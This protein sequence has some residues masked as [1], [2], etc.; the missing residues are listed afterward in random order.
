MNGY[1]ATIFPPLRRL[2]L[3]LSRDTA[4]LLFVAANLLMLSMETALAHSI[5]GTIRPN[6]WIPILFSP[7]AG[8]WI[9]AALWI[10]RRHP[11]LG[12]R[13]TLIP[14]WSSIVVGILGTW[15][16]LARGILLQG[17]PGQQVTLSRLIWSPPLLAPPAYVLIGAIGLVALWPVEAPGSTRFR[18]LKG[19]TEMPFTKSQL[20]FM[21]ASL[22]I[23]IAASSSVMDHARTGFVNPWL[24]APTLGGTFGAVVAF[25]LGTQA[26]PTRADLITYT[27]AI[28]LQLILGPTGLLLHILSDLGPDNAIIIERFIRQAPL[29]APMLF[30]DM[31]L[32]GLIALLDD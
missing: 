17:A 23:L 3:P 28:G 24:W 26:H 32:L 5:S 19:W 1:L 21:L 29:M 12:R 10:S 31:G 11:S 13:L 15:F 16:H 20:Y 14:L 4:A 6:E 7:P 30:A 9:L 25:F 8:L 27:A 22:G 2:K 18:G